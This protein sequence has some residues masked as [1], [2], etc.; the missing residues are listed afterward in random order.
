MLSPRNALSVMV[1]SM[2]STSTPSASPSRTAMY[3]SMERLFLRMVDGLV[4]TACSSLWL[5][6]HHRLSCRCPREGRSF[7]QSHHDGFSG[8][9]QPAFLLR[10]CPVAISLLVPSSAVSPT[11]QFQRSTLFSS[12]ELAA[13][14]KQVFALADDKVIVSTNVIYQ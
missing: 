8:C 10:C 4:S 3:A 5:A 6:L 11:L 13:L 1:L 7:R 9:Y 12:S 14:R 2:A